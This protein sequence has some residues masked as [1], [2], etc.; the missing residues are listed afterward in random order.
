[1][2][3]EHAAGSAQVFNARKVAGKL[4]A[5]FDDSRGLLHV[6]DAIARP[7]W[8]LRSHLACALSTGF[9]VRCADEGVVV[10]SIDP[11]GVQQQYRR[12]APSD[13]F[14]LASTLALGPVH[15]R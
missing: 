8:V 6:D 14:V 13:G 10:S 15:T 7:R 9:S 12:W 5:L 3:G 11:A 4:L 2:P 1:F